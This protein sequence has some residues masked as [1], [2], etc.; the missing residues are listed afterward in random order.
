MR[1]KEGSSFPDKLSETQIMEMRFGQYLEY[2]RVKKKLTLLSLWH[3]IDPDASMAGF[4]SAVIQGKQKP[5]LPET[6]LKFSS[7]FDK[8]QI[9]YLIR[10]SLRDRLRKELY[11]YFN[12]EKVY[13]DAILHLAKT[14]QKL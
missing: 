14:W 4:I 2:L 7:I 1:I 8:D 12:D 13:E 9:F 5:F 6:I 11:P 3:V 10:L